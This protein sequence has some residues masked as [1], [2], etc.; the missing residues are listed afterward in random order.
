MNL[1]I[2]MADTQQKYEVL[3]KVYGYSTFRPG[4]EEIIDYIME[5]KDGLVIMPT[6]GGKSICFQVPALCM[7][8][9]TIVVSPLIALMNDQVVALKQLG[10]SAEAV[11]SNHNSDELRRIVNA[12]DAGEVKLL[13][14]SPERLTNERFLQ[15]LKSKNISLIAVDEA[16]CVSV[17]GN[18]FRP[19]YAALSVLKTH[20]PETNIV[21]L[22]ATADKATQDDIA[23]QLKL[24]EPKTFISSFERENIIINVRPGL[25]RKKVIANFVKRHKDQSGIVY[26]LSRKSCEKVA[27]DL[28]N[29][30][31]EAGFYHAGMDA[32]DRTRIQQE[33]QEDK[34]QIVCATIAFGMGIDKSNIKWV[35]HYNMPKNLEGYYQEIGRAGRDGT[36]AKAVLYYSWA[37]FLMYK[38]FIDEGEG[39]DDFKYVQLAKLQRMW[40]YVSTSDCRTNLVLNYFGEYKT[41]RCQH[42]DNC[43]R[44]PKKVDGKVNVQ[45]A[46]SAVIRSNEQLPMGLLVDVLRGSQKYEVTSAGLQHLKTFGA[47]RD[48]SFVEWKDY[49]TQIIDKGL[50]R[51][52]YTDRLRLKTTPLSKPAIL[53]TEPIMLKAFERD[54][55]YASK[56]KQRREKKKTG[57]QL[58][59]EELVQELKSWRLKTAQGMGVPAYV[60]LTDKS[61]EGIASAKPTTAFDLEE[62]EGIGQK[63]IE[64]YGDEL[65]TVIQDYLRT[66]QHRKNLKGK[67]YLET[68]HLLKKGLAPQAIADEKGVNVVTIYSHF[69]HLF[70]QGEPID[71]Y[72]YL[73]ESDVQKVKEAYLASGKSNEINAINQLLDGSV[74]FYKIRMALALI[75]KKEES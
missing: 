70:K 10:V 44:P 12:I 18:D 59:E 63:R 43:L 5:G 20:F 9:M 32:A 14:V 55:D 33:F 74:E 75:E 68:M 34:L 41:E 3:K 69:A 51:I 30:G 27:A 40:E 49:I 13:Y 21:A 25:D 60:V 23:K 66:Q 65:L 16:H 46:I 61:I 45:K 35:I 24:V 67:T 72:Q 17:W 15:Y 73:T 54:A 52:D 48:L 6:G 8:G 62:V 56:P 36:E 37:D 28:K 1:T 39:N 57:T 22:T 38:R 2:E 64:N 31:I 47:G 58:I 42:C 4:Q 29:I 53:G 19:D 7:D 11:H 50:L 71:L 26:C